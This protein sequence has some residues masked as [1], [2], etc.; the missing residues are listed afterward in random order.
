[1]QEK[2]VVLKSKYLFFFELFVLYEQKRTY[3]LI[4]TISP[5][6]RRDGNL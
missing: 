6:M 2:I 3:S 4:Y 5:V 1:M